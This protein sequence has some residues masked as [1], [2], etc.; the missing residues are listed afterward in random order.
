MWEKQLPSLKTWFFSFFALSSACFLSTFELFSVH[1]YTDLKVAKQKSCILKNC[2]SL[3][4]AQ[5]QKT[6]PQHDLWMAFTMDDS[7]PWDLKP[8][9]KIVLFTWWFHCSDFPNHSK[10]LM[11]MC[12]WAILKKVR[13][14]SHF[15]KCRQT[16]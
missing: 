1:D 7:Q 5:I 2:F 13:P 14:N 4:Q 6:K 9:S 3:A 8:L 12:K 16:S 11:H 15:Q 10:I